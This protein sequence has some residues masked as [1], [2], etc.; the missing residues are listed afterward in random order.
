MS[1]TPQLRPTDF[2]KLETLT[3]REDRERAFA[4]SAIYRH[5][6]PQGIRYTKGTSVMTTKRSWQSLD[7]I[8]RSDASSSAAL[9]RRDMRISRVFSALT[10]VAGILTVAGTAASAREGLNLQE[11]NGTGAVLLAGGL[12]SVGFWITSGIFYGKTKRGYEEA[13][14]VYNDSLSVRL[15]LNTAAGDYIPAQGV[16]VDENGYIMLD[17]RERELGPSEAEADEAEELTAEEAVAEVPAEA[18]PAPA[19][20]VETPPAEALTPAEDEPEIPAPE[21]L[22]APSDSVVPAP[23]GSAAAPDSEP[24][25]LELWPR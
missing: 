8:L 12:A 2:Q 11:L 4:D 17:E 9:P 3:D 22:Q 10:V 15:G 25:A 21:V 20:E 19:L 16:L 13:I 6:E 23:G 14:E 1:L 7:A 18:D 5:E 24:R